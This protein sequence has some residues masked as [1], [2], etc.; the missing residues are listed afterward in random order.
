MRACAVLGSAALVAA[1]FIATA[2][3][4]AAG[5]TATGTT[6]TGPV[7]AD[8]DLAAASSGTYR[9]PF[10]DGTTVIV[11]DR[12]HAHSVVREFAVGA[13]SPIVAA[14]SGWIRAV[15]GASDT[16]HDDFVWIEHPNGE[17]SRYAGVSAA[18]VADRWAAGDWIDAGAVLGLGDGDGTRLEWEVAAAAAPGVPLTW[19]AV[20]GSIENGVHL[21]ARVCGIPGGALVPGEY[22]AAPC[23]HRPPTAVLGGGPLVVDEGSP[24]VLDATASFDPE[25]EPLT[26]RWDLAGQSVDPAAKPALTIADDFEGTVT[27][28]VYD[29][30]EGLRDAASG[31]IAVRNVPPSVEVVALPADEGGIAGIRATVADPGDDTLAAQVDW[32]DGTAPQAA[33][34]AE[35]AAGMDHAYGDDG[36]FPVTVTVVDDDGGVGA[37]AVPLEIVG[38]DPVVSLDAGLPVSFPGGAYSVTAVGGVITATATATDPG[39]DDLAFSWSTGRSVT[40]LNDRVST[41]PPLSPFGSFPARASHATEQTFAATGVDLIRVRV[42]DDDGR[43][44]DAAS[45]VIVTGAAVDAPG[46]AWWLYGF[47]GTGQTQLSAS[48]AAAYLDI[49]QSVSTVFSELEP[50]TT[51]DQAAA[52]LAPDG[53][54]ARDEA[55]AALLAAWLQFAS[56][57]VAWDAGIPLASG[58]EVAFLDLMADAES[59]IASPGTSDDELRAVGADLSRVS[60]A[61]G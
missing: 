55:R 29:A 18:T 26:Y 37:R 51:P 60:R 33:T 22:R 17:Y 23:T 56:G 35:L 24:L 38:V 43:A 54:G 19:S 45:P 31:E 57:A 15:A 40:A 2:L 14:A 16:A 44:T 52:V 13:D 50:V 58:R 53:D 34:I 39:S 7:I 8:N 3:P 46:R 11:R 48:D 28:S 20:D 49:V 5:T 32:G 25:G 4:A 61:A 9:V 30:V 1:G 6:T 59:R 10:A 42:S 41:D 36:A 27:L 21:T 47:V 12:H